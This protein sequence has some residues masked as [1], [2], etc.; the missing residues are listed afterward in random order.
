MKKS[1]GF[2]LIELLVVIAIIGILAAIVLVSLSSARSKAKDAA[3]QSDMNQ[4]RSAAEI[5]Y[6]DKTTYVNM[7]T[8]TSGTYNINKLLSDI[9]TGQGG[10]YQDPVTSATAY[11]IMAT[12]T[13]S[14]A[15]N[16][17]IDSSLA[18][19]KEAAGAAC[20]TT[21]PIACP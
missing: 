21:S 2:T 7:N 11:C 15:G 1:K 9:S 10:S 8:D 12:L 14:G 19:K 4:I 16:W 3:I 5:F 13:S 20:P 6:N 17:C 18:S